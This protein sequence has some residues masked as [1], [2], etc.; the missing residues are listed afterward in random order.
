M[1]TNP[2]LIDIKKNQALEV[3][4]HMLDGMTTK[5]ACAL[6]GISTQAFGRT[7]SDY[8][9]LI[10]ELN[11]IHI[12]KVSGMMNTIYGESEKNLQVIVDQCTVLRSQLEQNDPMIDRK[13]TLDM[14]LK[15]DKY[16]QGVVQKLTP[17][18]D[19]LPQPQQQDDSAKIDANRILKEM[20]GANLKRVSVTVTA[21]RYNSVD[22]DGELIDVIDSQ[23]Q[24]TAPGHSQHYL[25]DTHEEF[26]PPR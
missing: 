17:I 1:T 13:E 15:L 8:P 2:A 21:E 10:V 25:D 6:A 5:S 7:V 26:P 14:L 3:I 22:D 19:K 20:Q 24:E 18:M 16:I 4:G 23:A 12:G 9:E 11:K